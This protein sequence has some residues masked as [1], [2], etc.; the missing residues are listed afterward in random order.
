MTAP[1]TGL[2]AIFGLLQG[3]TYTDSGEVVRIQPPGVTAET[4]DV[5]SLTSTDAFREFI[6]SLKDGGEVT[7]VMH[8]DP[9]TVADAENQTLLKTAVE[10]TASGGRLTF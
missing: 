1:A 8:F 6:K 7:V 5:T 3:S 4:I 2:G 10:G 9:A